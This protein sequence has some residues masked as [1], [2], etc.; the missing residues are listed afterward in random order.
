MS[1]ENSV[2]D[3][4]TASVTFEGGHTIL[5]PVFLDSTDHVFAPPFL[6]PKNTWHVN[7]IVQQ[8]EGQTPLVFDDVTFASTVDNLIID[9]PGDDGETTW[10]TTFT[11]TVTDVNMLSCTITLRNPP[12]G[13]M[14]VVVKYCGDPTIA[15][16]KDPLG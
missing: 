2:A 13:P 7:F 14:D 6:I 1:T 12:N 10:H 8:P 9:N 3:P 16:V 11:N 15:V 4:I 5:V